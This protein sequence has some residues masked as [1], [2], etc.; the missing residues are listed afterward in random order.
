MSSLNVNVCRSAGPIPTFINRGA[1]GL[2]LSLGPTMQNV[3]EN[4][5]VP[6]T[7]LVEAAGVLFGGIISSDALCV[8]SKTVGMDH[9]RVTPCAAHDSY[10][11]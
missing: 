5:V 3:P 9:K 10:L 4:V 6:H 11:F 2:K 1:H 7:T 8:L